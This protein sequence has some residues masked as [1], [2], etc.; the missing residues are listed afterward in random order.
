MFGC[1]PLVYVETSKAWD[2]MIQFGRAR[3][4]GGNV[5]HVAAELGLALQDV[6]DFSA[7]INPAGLP[8][9]AAQ[10]LIRDAGDQALLKQ[11]PDPASTELRLAL[12]RKLEARPE[13]IVIGGGSTALIIATIRA[14]APRTCLCPVPAFS[15]YQAACKATQC[16]FVPFPLQEKGAFRPDME[17][18]SGYLSEGD[19]DGVILNNP[20]NPSGAVLEATELTQL[21]NTAQKRGTTVILDEAFVDFVPEV[22]LTAEASERP[23][24]V[25]IR[26]LTKFYGCPALRVGYAVT[27]ATFAEHIK[28]QLP[29]WPVTTLAVNVLTE[30]LN[31]EGYAQATLHENDHERLY[32]AAAFQQLGLQ[33]FPSAANFLLLKLPPGAPSSGH[34]RMELLERHRILVR[35]CDSFEGLEKGRF[36]RVA[37]LGRSENERLVAALGSVLRGPG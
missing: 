7:N 16:Q 4:H 1:R 23:A 34:L 25:V 9:R 10:R 12:S 35:N 21:V 36:L 14:L 6:V 17:E 24:L 31:D 30:A 32:L 15:E 33:V 28:L 18:L 29:T 11:Y 22:S 26:S 13:S 8:E 20:H 19:F 37:I 2:A 27:S 3:E 5:H